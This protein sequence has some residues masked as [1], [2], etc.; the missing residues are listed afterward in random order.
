MSTTCVT[1]LPLV[2]CTLSQWSGG[3]VCQRCT[4]KEEKIAAFHVVL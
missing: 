2:A 4:F 3:V 1:N